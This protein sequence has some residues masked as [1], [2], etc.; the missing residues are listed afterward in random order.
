MLNLNLLR[1]YRVVLDQGSFSRA[2]ETLSITQS[3]VSRAVQELERQLGMPLLERRARGVVPTEAGALLGEHA[4][5]IFAH[6]QVALEALNELRDLRRGRLSIGASSTIGI[7]L[8]PSMLGEYHRLYPGIELFLDIGNTQQVMEH[9]RS[10]RIE[11]AY[12]EGPV[13]S[14]EH[15]QIVPWR[16]D[17]LVVIAAPDHPL[18]QRTDLVAADLVAMP[19]V[20]REPGSGTREVM[21]QALA[22]RGIAVRTVMEL[23]STE[24]VKQ[25]VSAGLGLSIVSWATI[26]MELDSAR[27]VALDVADLSIRRQLSR[28]H[29]RDRPQSRALQEWLKLA[30][31]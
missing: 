7:Y 3:A 12:V 22:A 30:G 13:A 23:G 19:F 11:V 14:D 15:V 9:L 27:L 20:L 18:A 31:R 16:D 26:Q 17:E 24:A 21:E 6:E 8:L 28:A 5:R 25:A 10:Y 2:A 1:I 29:V 4:R